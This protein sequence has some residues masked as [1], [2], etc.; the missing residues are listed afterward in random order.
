MLTKL[1]APARLYA[2]YAAL[3]L[4]LPWSPDIVTANWHIRFPSE[5]LTL[6]AGISLLIYLWR[7]PSLFLQKLQFGQ[8][9]LLA[10]TGWIIWLS[11][12]L[13]F[14]I[15]QVVSMKYWIVETGQYWVF[16]VGLWVFREWWQRLLPFFA[17]SMAGIVLFTLAHHFQY[18]FRADQS[19]LAPMPFFPDHTLYSAVLV[20]LLPNVLL[21]FRRPFAGVLIVLFLTGL[22]FAGCRAAWLSLLLA[23]ML[24]LPLVYRNKWKWWLLPALVLL[25]G[26]VSMKTL[27]ADKL[28]KDISSLERLNRYSSAWRMAEQRPFTGFGPGT[29]QF[30][31]LVFQRPEEMTRISITD[32]ARDL[33]PDQFGRGGGAHSEYFQALAENG[34][35]GLL[36]WLLLAGVSIFTGIKAYLSSQSKENQWIILAA[37]FSL[38]TFFIHAFFNNFLHD[39][40][41]ALLFWGQLAW[42]AGKDGMNTSLNNSTSSTTQPFNSPIP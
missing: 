25:A 11:V 2:V 42:L 35:P 16:F 31:Y 17:C 13:V 7:H 29:F 5:A 19:M 10:G 21:Q 41:I 39:G 20:M 27:L 24:V 36:F 9:I 3:F 1:P 8:P 28:G 30:Q 15:M 38:L 34:W 26:A 37:L 14:S 40:R 33:R 22:V 18:Q 12:S 32:P 4:L 6:A 23:G